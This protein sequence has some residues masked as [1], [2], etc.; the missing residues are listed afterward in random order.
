MNNMKRQN[1]MIL[2]DEHLPSQKVSNILIEKSIII[3]APRKK[4]EMAKA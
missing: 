3:L 2:K 4:E 1:D